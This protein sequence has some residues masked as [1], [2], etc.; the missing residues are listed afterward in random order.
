[1][2]EVEWAAGRELSSLRKDYEAMRSN[3]GFAL[4]EKLWPI[5]K[6]YN[7]FIMNFFY[8]NRLFA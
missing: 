2:D 3:S 8:R 5:S 1:M 7:A 4:L 6:E